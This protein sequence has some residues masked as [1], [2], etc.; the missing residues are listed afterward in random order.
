MT[1]FHAALPAVIAFL[2]RE[3]RVTYRTLIYAYGLDNRLLAESCSELRLRHLAI[4]EGGKVL[5]W[6]G[7]SHPPLSASVAS[8]ATPTHGLTASPEIS[9]TEIAPD[10]PVVASEPVRNISEAGWSS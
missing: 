9:L 2:Q 3:G 8:T 6:I 7:E 4:D 10:K 5:T 1:R